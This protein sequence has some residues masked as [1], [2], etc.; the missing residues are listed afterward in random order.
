MV[1]DVDTIAIAVA[2]EAA[3]NVVEVVVAD[4][5]AGLVAADTAE[6]AVVDIVDAM[7]V[8][9][10]LLQRTR[11]R[12]LNSLVQVDYPVVIDKAIATDVIGHLVV[13]AVIALN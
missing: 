13:L 4:T 8:I 6:E 7:V 2:V 12:S 9:M 5:I 10:D 3:D 1:E 11:S